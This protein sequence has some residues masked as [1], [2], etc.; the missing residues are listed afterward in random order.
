MGTVIDHLMSE[1]Q[2]RVIQ[3]FSDANGVAHQ[4][5]ESGVMALLLSR[6]K[7]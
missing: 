3:S 2:V 5:G 7:R 1:H 6:R 4:A